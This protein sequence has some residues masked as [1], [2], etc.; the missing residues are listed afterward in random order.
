M[1]IAFG[2]SWKFNNADFIAFDLEEMN[3]SASS[4]RK[5]PAK[6]SATFKPLGKPRVIV[7]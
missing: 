5:A 2:D 7:K 1:K 6:R 4:K 3:K